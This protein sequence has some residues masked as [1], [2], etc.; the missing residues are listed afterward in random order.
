MPKVTN[1][2]FN[3]TW[4][5]ET[6]NKL[7]FTETEI[8]NGI[9]YKGSVV[10]NQLNGV[11]HILSQALQFQQ[12]SGGMYSST[13]TY[14][15]GNFV[16]ILRT[17][18]TT[19]LQAEVYYCI[20]DKDGNGIVNQPPVLDATL[21]S[22]NGVDYYSGGYVN[23]THWQRVDV[24]QMNT[25]DMQE[26]APTSTPCIIELCRIPS[27][28]DNPNQKELV[29]TLSADVWITSYLGTTNAC[30]VNLKL[31]AQYIC[32]KMNFF[33]LASLDY[34]NMPVP[35][36]S[37]GEVIRSSTNPS[38][39]TS[40]VK[41]Y[42]PAYNLSY[43][44]ALTNQTIN[45]ANL[46]NG[47]IAPYGFN[48]LIGYTTGADGWKQWAIYLRFPESNYIKLWGKSNIALSISNAVAEANVTI[49]NVIPVRPN[50]GA[51]NH[52]EDLLTLREYDTPATTAQQIMLHYSRGEVELTT[53]QTITPLTQ[54]KFGC[55]WILSRLQ[56]TTTASLKEHQGRH[57]RCYGGDK[58]ALGGFYFNSKALSDVTYAG[59]QPGQLLEPA[60]PNIRGMH[61]YGYRGQDNYSTT[62]FAGAFY[63]GNTGNAW[64]TSGG[65]YRMWVNISLDRDNTIFKDTYHAT[66][67]ILN[68]KFTNHYS[69]E[70]YNASNQIQ[71]ERKKYADVTT[72]A[73]SVARY[74]KIF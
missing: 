26:Y 37:F 54:A 7:S 61:Y 22:N 27:T 40:I 11:S 31:N 12:S 14:L 43:T 58:W 60:V 1:Y 33:N 56:G 57:T 71:S 35:N 53:A 34:F 50:G 18:A 19:A 62:S 5:Q 67:T 55:Y 24:G 68:N 63:G 41:D 13:M 48:V 66:E 8:Q 32:D 69:G 28:L 30:S 6:S 15:K 9:A 74:I 46:Y 44:N 64:H 45:A 23:R 16:T 73:I 38:A 59:T 52:Y 2:P 39:S 17:T 3:S 47:T 29:K 65:W 25:I 70:V 4:A 42:V 10:S 21:Y 51:S 72:K 36:V 49:A 20:N